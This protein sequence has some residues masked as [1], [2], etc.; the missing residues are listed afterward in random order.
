MDQPPTITVPQGQTFN[1]FLNGDLVFDGPYSQGTVSDVSDSVANGRGGVL[2]VRDVA[3]S[4]QPPE[5]PNE[6]PLIAGLIVAFLLAVECAASFAAWR[7][8]YAPALG[9]PFAVVAVAWRSRLGALAL[10]LFGSGITAVVARKAYRLG[11]VLCAL[12]IP[13]VVGATGRLYSPMQ[14]IGWQLRSASSTTTSVLRQAW[15]IA[16]GVALGSSFLLIAAWRR[17]GTSSP[18]MSHGSAYWGSPTLLM[19]D[20]GVLVGRHDD[21]TL[22]LGGEGH[23][24][25]VAPTRS[26]K[27]V[28]CVI[29]NLLD[30]PGSAL[31]TDPK[32]ENYAVTARWR[33]SAGHD[34]HALD[35]FELVG[36]LASYNPLDLVDANSL[37]AVDDA[38]MLADMLVLPEGKESGDQSFWNEEA[39][40][41][42]TGLILHVASSDRPETRTLA[43][44]RDLLTLA[45]ESFRTLLTTMSNSEAAGGLVSRAAARLL[46]KA[47]RERS[48]VIST[49]QSHTHFL[50]SPRMKR[51]LGTSTFDF[52]SL[53][54]ESTTVYLVLP[55]DRI[56]GYA[57]WL[58]LMIA[59]GLLAVTRT[60]G[61]PRE[62]VLFLLDEFA[63]LRRMHPVQRDIGL[64]GGYGVRFWLVLQ[65]LSQLRSTYGDTWPTFLANVDLLQAFGTSDWDTAEYLSKMTGESTIR[66]ASENHSKGVSRGRNANHQEGAGSSTS[67]AGRRL[68]FPDEVRRLPRDQQLLFVKGMAPMLSER[69]NYLTDVEFSARANSNPLYAPV[70]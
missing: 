23:I 41:L 24:L 30:H 18:T 53:K 55:P 14:L 25:T 56:D 36:E 21:Q 70:G 44:M 11:G 29:P 34:V 37:D 28:S 35:P 13:F 52:S 27:G 67:E 49:A 1:V 45:P 54:R 16:A 8:N 43:E 65:D 46:Q 6:R 26:G 33:R 40:G 38:R 51:V 19:S 62:R 66:V 3:G 32:G 15:A 64:A 50:D 20:R 9:Q 58:R 61:Q 10:L 59:C 47:D 4:R 39:R 5:P 48:G 68:M 17:R 2:G 60:A 42:L 12:A 31:I 69:V 7:F 57:R 63:H 22:R